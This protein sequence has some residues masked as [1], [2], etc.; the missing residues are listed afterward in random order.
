MNFDSIPPKK[1]EEP[2]NNK[3]DLLDSDSELIEL[4]NKYNKGDEMPVGFEKAEGT[5]GVFNMILD[6]KKIGKFTLFDPISIGRK[7]EIKVKQIGYININN[8]FRNKG[9]GK[10]FYINL[11]HYLNTIDGSVLESGDDTTM[12]S[13]RVWTSLYKDGLVIKQETN[14]LD[15]KDSYRFK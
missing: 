5:L 9:V 13:D 2:L 3:I 12:F 11:N 6:G 15:N 4:A 10:Q 14:I 1:N 8:A 7:S